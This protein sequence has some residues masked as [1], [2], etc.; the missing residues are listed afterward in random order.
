MKMVF[1]QI[2]CFF[3]VSFYPG[4]IRIDHFLDEKLYFL[5][6]IARK[7]LGSFLGTW[8]MSTQFLYFLKNFEYW[9]P[10]NRYL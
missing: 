4:A 7:S 2:L 8:N 9:F 3:A 6:K 10:I 5:R 1:F